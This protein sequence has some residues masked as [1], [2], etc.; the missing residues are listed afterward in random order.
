MSTHPEDQYGAYDANNA[1][2]A[3]GL[4]GAHPQ[5]QP[6]QSPPNV[7][8]PHAGPPPAYDEYAD[9][10]IAHGWENAYDQTQP[11][12]VTPLADP[13]YG[14]HAPDDGHGTAEQP[15]GY[16]DEDASVFVD[17]SGRRRRLM[18]RVAI[19]VGA[20]CVLFI[21]VVVAGL[22]DSGPGSPLP[23][24]NGNQE[25]AKQKARVSASPT[26]PGDPG[27]ATT[28]EPRPSESSAPGTSE[29]TSAEP[30]T[31][32][33]TGEKTATPTTKAPSTTAAP[34]TTAPGRGS[35]GDNPGRGQGSTK[36]PK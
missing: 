4:N 27:S 21:A 35:S 30:S 6:P 36:G 34:T 9:P 17:G 25:G 19:A 12:P 28:G 11:L 18:S 8:H 15:G 13:E 20:V 14:Q 33:S 16:G 32:G 5:G 24:V 1:N 23:W 3:Y 22:F 2:G 7:Y 26:S 31:S 29:K 10:A